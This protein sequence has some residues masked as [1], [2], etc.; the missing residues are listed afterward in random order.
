MCNTEILPGN[1][2]S[3][4]E[5]QRIVLGQTFPVQPR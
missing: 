4:A 3:I 5:W 2:L 1:D